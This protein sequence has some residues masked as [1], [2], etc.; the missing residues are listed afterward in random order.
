MRIVFA[1]T[2][3]FAEAALAAL[4]AAGHELPLVLT[5][6]DRPA[7]RGLR[8][9]PSPVKQ[10]S[11][12]HALPVFQP[13]TLKCLDAQQ[14]LRDARPDAMVVAAYGLI[15][16]QAVLDIPPLGCLNIHASLL[17]R[18]RGAAPIQRAILAGDEK[19]GI[20]IM[21]MEAGLDT[22]PVLLQEAIS[23]ARDETA[24]SVH[25]RLARLGARLI[26]TALE[27]LARGEL[28]AVPQPQAGAT[29]AAKISKA[30]T[31]IDWREPADLLERRVR[32]YNPTP[33]ARSSFAGE[34]IK[35]WRAAAD[36]NGEGLPGAILSAT[37]QGI[38]VACGSG[39][40]RILELQRSGGKRLSA[41]AFVQ[42]FALSPGARFGA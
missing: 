14:R 30:E 25:D 35:I 26:V 37:P 27:R 21:R 39:V 23:V 13:A 40:L 8:D 10:L 18:W 42:G 33:A 6:P 41:G 11:L 16:P 20:S 9:A 2:P 28:T 34:V 31:Q 5:Q 22:G 24:G 17:P 29:Y 38:V 12:R 4:L 3:A 7:G 15:L 1:G 32:A 19:T 36:L